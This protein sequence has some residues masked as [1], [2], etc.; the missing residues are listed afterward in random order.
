VYEGGRG[1]RREERG[2]GE[3]EREGG[4]GSGGVRREKKIADTRGAFFRIC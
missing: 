3:K 4:E 2:E 1:E